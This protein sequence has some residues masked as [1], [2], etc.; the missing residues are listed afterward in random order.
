M[1]KEFK[2]NNFDLLRIFAATQVVLAHGVAHL[3]IAKPGWWPIVDAFPGVPIFFAISGF[4][5]S[6]SFERSS[7]LANYLRNR[8]LRIYPALWCCVL[9]TV[10]V[11]ACFGFS[12][13]N[14]QA[15]LWIP[16]QLVGLIYTPGFLR[17][18]GFG[19]YNGSLWTIPI[20]LQFY[21]L[22]PIAYL[23]S[24]SETR[25]TLLIGLAFVAFVIAGYLFARVTPPLGEL[26]S[27]PLAHKLL[28]YSFIPHIYLF[29]AG[30]LLQRWHVQRSKWI[31]GKGPL[32]LAAFLVFHFALPYSPATYIIGT[33]LLGVA[34]VSIAFTAP[35]VSSLVLRGND[36]SY[37]VYIYHGLIIN[38]LLERH[39]H[40]HAGHLVLVVVLTFI[41][42]FA[43]WRFVERPFL[44]RKRQTIHPADA[45]RA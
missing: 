20:E 42:G 2:V 18:F 29:L 13:F 4:L 5:I 25:R 7:S 21:L 32:W 40:G 19:S 38:L 15:L 33:L 14:A 12:F 8:F 24:R 45:A 1:E 34:A 31:A 30:M 17:S 39:I 44:K 22:L 9:L 11:A 28:R 37:G 26:E 43:S 3:G 36:I 23:V 35:K 16:T 6:A 41:A 10:V 27:E